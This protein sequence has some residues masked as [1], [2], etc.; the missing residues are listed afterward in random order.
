MRKSKT[1]QIFRSGSYMY[2][3]KR[4]E[5]DICIQIQKNYK[6]EAEER[7]P[8]EQLKAKSVYFCLFSSIQSVYDDLIALSSSGK[9]AIEENKEEYLFA[10]N[11]NLKEISTI[12]L[13]IPKQIDTS[14]PKA[15]IEQ[16]PIKMINARFDAQDSIIHKMSSRLESIESVLRHQS[17]LFNQVLLQAQ[18]PS[19]K[20]NQ[21]LA[22]NQFN[23]QIDN[24][25]RK[26]INHNNVKPL[27]HPLLLYEEMLIENIGFLNEEERT[28]VS[29]WIFKDKQRICKWKLLYNPKRGEDNYEECLRL[30]YHKPSIV[31]LIESTF[32][33]KFGGYTS[34]GWDTPP[35]NDSCKQHY[36][37]IAIIL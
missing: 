29:N 18:I 11:I 32:G 13:N 37:F 26:L 7:F 31:V 21:S 8:I 24:K 23:F 12:T 15:I 28:M 20:N 33:C 22:I 30:S 5:A 4:N 3:I 35:D 34:V 17:E 1:T 6:V 19:K 25:K 9:I 10:L 27:I 14:P 16:F 2:S 36:S